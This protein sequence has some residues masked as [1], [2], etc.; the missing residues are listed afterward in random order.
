MTRHNLTNNV[1]SMTA[2]SNDQLRAAAP[3]VF[4]LEP[5]HQMSE[6]YTF[7]PTIAVVEQMRE[8]GFMPV[9]AMQSRTRIEGKRDFTKHL[10]RFR[11]MRSGDQPITR[12][13]GVVYPELVLVNSHDGM[14][15]YMIDAGLF[16]QICTNGMVVCDSLVSQMHVRHT[17][18]A[19]GIIEASFEVIDQ[20]PKVIDSIE[21][22]QR[23]RLEAPQAEAFAAAA[24]QLRYEEGQ[25]PITPQQILQPRRMEDNTPTLWNTFNRTQEALVNGG[26]RGR[27][28]ET[29]RRVRTRPVEGIS[30][31]TKL[32]KALWT[33][34]EE[35]R[36]LMS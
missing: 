2:L 17:G 33:L 15:S 9:Q 18:S 10:I 26:L 7:I 11:D 4:A 35:M 34:A 6:K 28:A 36:K 19:D 1:R 30:E 21:S 25:A 22:F 23:L 13:L 8:S 20:M 5:W 16:R 32:N 29:R 27:H 31:N 12:A 3:S 24:L 14:S